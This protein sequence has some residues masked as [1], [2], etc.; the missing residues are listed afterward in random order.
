MKKTSFNRN[1][2]FGDCHESAVCIDRKDGEFNICIEFSDGS[3]HIE[4]FDSLTDAQAAYDEW[5]A[6]EGREGIRCVSKNF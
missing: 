4:Q 1:A 3:G 6:R 2:G 5:A